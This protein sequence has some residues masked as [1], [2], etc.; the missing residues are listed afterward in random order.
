[1]IL[2]SV[3]K[4]FIMYYRNEVEYLREVFNMP[5]THIRIENFKSIKR[6]DLD[7]NA[8]NGLIGANG[9]G[10][11]NILEA[12]YYFYTNLTE[13]VI[14]E[15]IFDINNKFSNQMSITF[16]Y[17]LSDFSKISKSNT[18]ESEFPFDDQKEESKYKSYYK[19]I[20]SLAS[21]R[22]DKTY[23]LRLTQIKER[24]MVWSEPFEKRFIIKS[25]FPLF[26][27]NT[28]D[29]D[30]TEWSQV[31]NILGELGKVSHEERYLLENKISDLIQQNANISGKMQHVQAILESSGVTIRSA[32]A[33]EFAKYLG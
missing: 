20:I 6:C 29:L 30:I 21:Q 33:K 14:N 12:I 27:I 18:A 2:I 28:R 31:W 7:L 16:T 25:L 11:T 9:T 17:D 26:Y 8:I 4:W 23:S 5:L 1:M 3:E 32:T 15:E 13:K 24:G 10:K 19:S 22:K